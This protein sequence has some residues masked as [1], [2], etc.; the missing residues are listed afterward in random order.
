MSIA[1]QTA[2]LVTA[3][4]GVGTAVKNNFYPKKGGEIVG[5]AYTKPVS[6]PFTTVP[7]ID[8]SK[9]NVFHLGTMTGSIL[10]MTVQNPVDGQT[11]NIRMIPNANGYSV[12]LPST[13]VATGQFNATAGTVNW[14]VMTWFAGLG[15]WE[16]VWS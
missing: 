2:L 8:A 13:I 5:R 16:A 14:L 10:N 3:V 4:G 9:S 6:V 7:V 12:N 15:R 1:S 11:I